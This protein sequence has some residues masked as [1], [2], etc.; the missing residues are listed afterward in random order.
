MEGGLRQLRAAEEGPRDAERAVVDVRAAAGPGDRKVDAVRHG[1]RGED[2]RRFT[3]GL[4]RRRGGG[5]ARFGDAAGDAQVRRVEPRGRAQDCEEARQVRRSTG[6]DGK[7]HGDK[8]RRPGNVQPPQRGEEQAL[9]GP[10]VIR[11]GVWR[12]LGVC[13]GH[14]WQEGV[15][16]SGQQ[17]KSLGPGHLDFWPAHR[18]GR[19]RRLARP[20]VVDRRVRR[21]SLRRPRGSKGPAAPRGERAVRPRRRRRRLCAV[22]GVEP[23]IIYRH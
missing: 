9:E 18:H 20:R 19:R 10:G 8:H 16:H 6:L 2:C 21:R 3:G 23:R 12:P 7:V 5:A 4:V 17:R 13:E 1:P 11:A 22:A 14:P 15:L